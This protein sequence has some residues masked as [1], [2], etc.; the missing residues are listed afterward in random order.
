MKVHLINEE[1]VKRLEA[2]ADEAAMMQS[3]STDDIVITCGSREGPLRL[4]QTGSTALGIQD[5]P[6]QRSNRC[7]PAGLWTL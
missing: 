3:G 7:L 4:R 2:G 1:Q 6:D 5:Y